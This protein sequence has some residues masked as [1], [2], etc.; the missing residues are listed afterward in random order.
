LA[1]GLVADWHWWFL[2]QLKGLGIHIIDAV[3]E[4]GW[5]SVNCLVVGPGR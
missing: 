2:T 3:E 4:D 5:H 1:V